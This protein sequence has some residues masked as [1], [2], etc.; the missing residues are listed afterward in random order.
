MEDTYSESCP[1]LKFADKIFTNNNLTERKVDGYP[2]TNEYDLLAQNSKASPVGDLSRKDIKKLKIVFDVLPRI[3][4]FDEDAMKN[5][6][7]DLYQRSFPLLD[8]S[9]KHTPYG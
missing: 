7:F 6:T 2:S 1:P 4:R 3:S 5:Y 8:R 9:C